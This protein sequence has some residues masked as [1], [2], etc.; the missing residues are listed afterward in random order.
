MAGTA[1]RSFLLTTTGKQK[2]KAE[3]Q[4]PTTKNAIYYPNE[5]GKATAKNA[6]YYPNEL[7][8]AEP[9]RNYKK[10]IPKIEGIEGYVIE[11]SAQAPETETTA[12]V[13]HMQLTPMAQSYQADTL[14]GLLFIGCFVAVSL[15][16][17]TKK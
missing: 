14:G 13:E 7:G 4:N 2:E 8:K 17:V 12:T 15:L 6:I 16:M 9:F 3:M 10:T 11:V 5:L 1:I